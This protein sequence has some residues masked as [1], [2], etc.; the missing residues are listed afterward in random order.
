MALRPRGGVRVQDTPTLQG[1]H[2]H[3]EV[4]HR[5]ASHLVSTPSEEVTLY[6][7]PLHSLCGQY[8]V[9]Y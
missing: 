2:V 6:L 4:E 8:S 9:Y 5:N 3:W 7:K 1:G